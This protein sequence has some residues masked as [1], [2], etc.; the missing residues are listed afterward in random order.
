MSPEIRILRGYKQQPDAQFTASAGAA[1]NGLKDHPK[2]LNPA[3]DLNEAQAVL[4]ALN[5]AIAAQPNTGLAG[6]ALKN[7][8]RAEMI[9]ILNK[10]AHYAQ[11]HCD[12][13]VAA[14]IDAGF[15]IANFK[16]TPIT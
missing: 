1:I 6:T 14:V 7:K 3:V 5:A 9:A 15:K 13:D 11:D 12:G 16:R 2:L 8:K 4:D 10:L